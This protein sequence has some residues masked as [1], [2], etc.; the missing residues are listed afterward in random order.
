MGRRQII[1][2][3]AVAALVVVAVAVAVAI[4][5]AVASSLAAPH[6]IDSTCNGIFM[7]V[8]RRRIMGKL[9]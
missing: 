8:V 9:S 5:V 6:V 4:R 3:A 2:V 7:I 1:D